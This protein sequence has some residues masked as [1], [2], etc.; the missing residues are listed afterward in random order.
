MAIASLGL[1][2][3][4]TPSAVRAGAQAAAGPEAHRVRR[5]LVLHS[6]HAGHPWTDREEQGIDS[7]LARRPERIEQYV[8]YL[9]ARRFPDLVAREVGDLR[10][11]YAG[12]GLDVVLVTD[13]DALDL[14]VANR[15][16]L[17]ENVPI[18]FC[19]INDYSDSLLR[20]ER[21]ITGVV[22][23]IDIA[24]TLEVALRFHPGTREI[25]VVVGPSKTGVANRALFE[26]AAA[27]LPPG[28]AVRF[29]VSPDVE[30]LR[31]ALRA[32][33]PPRLAFL[34]GQV[35]DAAGRTLPPDVSTRL[36]A[37]AG[38]PLYSQW[39]FY[40]GHGIVG[41][42]LTTGFEQGRTAAAMAVRILEGESA[43][44]IPVVRQS[45]NR[46][47]FDHAVLERFGIPERRLP[48]GSAIVNEPRGFVSLYGRV[49][50]VAGAI[51]LVL[52]AAVLVLFFSV[53]RARLA[54]RALAASKEELE[55]VNAFLDAN[56]KTLRGL[57]PICASCKKIRDDKGYWNRIEAYLAEH[58]DAHF[59]H[60]MCPEC[61]KQLGYPE[62]E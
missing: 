55:R 53:R 18:V 25:L 58:L 11:K 2:A 62:G 48:A 9:D 47:M 33:G 15:R 43:D 4:M 10:A 49:V 60:G 29:M 52:S 34:L 45:P 56:V 28:I 13:N 40:L 50:A 46:Y 19:G 22:E 61:L 59:T 14:V 39:D 37:P 3:A 6:Y 57:L 41:G 42:M 51:I 30:G 24:A 36:V 16:L 1:L 26:K 35:L 44:R 38:V 31:A 5:V 20:G 17:F 12:L 23:E 8:E 21:G 54:E 7:V 32:P 27:A